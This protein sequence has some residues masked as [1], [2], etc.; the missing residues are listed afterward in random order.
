[1]FIEKNKSWADFSDFGEMIEN[2]KKYI[3][4]SENE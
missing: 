2:N 1:L 4:Y 3:K